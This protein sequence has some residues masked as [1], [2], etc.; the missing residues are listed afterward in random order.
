MRKLLV[1]F[2][3]IGMIFALAVQTNAAPI[4]FDFQGTVTGNISTDFDSLLSVDD[5]ISG[6]MQF[7]FSPPPSHSIAFPITGGY[8]AP[9]G[10]VSGFNR[11]FSGSSSTVASWEFWDGTGP[12]VAVGT[13]II[14]L[15]G[16]FF[17]INIDGSNAPLSD[18]L[19]LD[20]SDFFNVAIVGERTHDT[21][22]S[23]WSGV[24]DVELTYASLQAPEPATMLLIGTG[25][26]GLVGFKRRFKA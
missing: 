24:A 11:L 25:L 5:V 2:C 10:S 13:D 9:A 8:T 20:A 1:L 6:S 7:D 19:A 14:S 21:G 15:D 4:I 3:A 23:S 17:A 12:S 18:Y 16:I 26:V 22:L